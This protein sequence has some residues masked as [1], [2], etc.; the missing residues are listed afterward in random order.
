MSILW[1][2][3]AWIVIGFFAIEV[4]LW[5]FFRKQL[6]TNILDWIISFIVGDESDKEI[7]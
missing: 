5:F 2:V 7:K 1:I 3:L 6:L 4:I